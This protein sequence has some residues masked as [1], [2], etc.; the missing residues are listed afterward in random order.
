MPKN[1]FKQLCVMQGTTLNDHCLSK[2]SFVNFFKKKAGCRIKL[3][4]EVTTLPNKGCRKDIFFFVHNDDMN[5][6]HT[7]KLSG[8]V[9]LWKDVVLN[10]EH[11]VYPE[12][13]INKYLK[14][15]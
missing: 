1:N 2:D 5:N 8:E 3:A 13:V 11:K 12:S 4:E 6:F 14:T 10:N 15:L 9:K 7:P